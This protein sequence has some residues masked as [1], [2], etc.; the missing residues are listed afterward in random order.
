MFLMRFLQFCFIFQWK[1][2]DFLF[3]L[4]SSRARVCQHRQTRKTSVSFFGFIIPYHYFFLFRF[5]L[6]IIIINGLR[7]ELGQ[8]GWPCRLAS[9]AGQEG[10]EAIADFKGAC[11]EGLK[12]AK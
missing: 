7:G 11:G 1:I 6:F 9:Q 4:N 12:L 10:W 3:D 2:K 5:I 8:A